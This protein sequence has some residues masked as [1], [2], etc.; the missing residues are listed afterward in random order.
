MGKR[1]ARQHHASD[2][3]AGSTAS[4]RAEHDFDAG[5]P[6]DDAVDDRR[7]QIR[8]AVLEV[9]KSGSII[10]VLQA[11]EGHDR[12]P[13]EQLQGR[14]VADIWPDAP[15]EFLLASVKAAI[16]GRQVH[17]TEYGAGG[18]AA[19]YEI[20]SIPQG[21]DRALLVV[22]DVSA[23]KTALSR[24]QQ[25]AYVDEAT[26]LPNREFLHEELSKCI[27]VLRLREGRAAVICFD[28][29]QV[30]LHGNSFGTR[31]QD[32]IIKEL[33]SRLTHELR[34]ANQSDV[35]DYERY[36]IA[37]RIE[38]RQFGVVLPIIESGSD[39]EGVTQRLIESLQQPIKIAHREVEVTARAGIALFPQD[40]NDAE[41][42]FENAIAAMEDARNSQVAPY[43]FHSGTVKLRALQRQDLDLELRAALEREE[44]TLEFL[45]IVDAKT[46]KATS[47]EALLRWP[48]QIFG[49]QSIRKVVALAEN[50]GLI[51]P[52]GDWVL[53]E[54]CTALRRLHDAGFA[55]LRL[56]IN[57]SVQEFS[58]RAL[59]EKILEI[60]DEFGLEPRHL[61]V[62]I[63]EYTLFRDAMKQYATCARLKDAGLGVVVDDY[64]TG[65]CSL[66]HLSRSP[67]DAV[68]I[69]NNFV[70][71]LIADAVDRAT[72]A[73][74]TA[75]AHELGKKI[76]AE[77]VETEGQAMILAEQ[78]CDFLQGF[79]FARPS[80]AEVLEAYLLRMIDE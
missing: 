7:E 25:L 76:I 32:V 69:E 19:H 28:I 72:C 33:A 2:R 41:S 61:D 47:V 59:I 43:K 26:K 16:S 56:A 13:P 52:I 71:N 63:S 57:L 31:Q 66:A 70:S 67:V 34:G 10:R 68:K 54:S 60:L 77:G 38:F 8:Q 80:S 39:A 5:L 4:S 74:V 65:A 23:R 24:M 73:A 20:I 75:M 29:D 17:S 46:R 44:F 30:D 12:R 21:R 27:D 64:G 49:L 48:Q 62:E 3:D 55:E 78:G 51:L 58:H 37:A 1:T 53:R 40:G 35:E 18:D 36:S 45:P 6:A 79:L 22:R 11:P 42:L 50:T 14:S 15:A 9:A